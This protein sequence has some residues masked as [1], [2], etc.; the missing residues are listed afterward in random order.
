[1]QDQYHVPI[2]VHLLCALAPM[3][4]VLVMGNGYYIQ[5]LI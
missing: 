2:S 3:G 4:Y 1:M 5:L